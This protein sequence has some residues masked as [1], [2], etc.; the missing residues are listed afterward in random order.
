MF[1]FFVTPLAP[2]F[3]WVLTVNSL[4]LLLFLLFPLLHTPLLVYGP[5][6]LIYV[7][8]LQA[9]SMVAYKRLLF[10]MV[11]VNFLGL[12][13][14]H[15]RPRLNMEVSHVEEKRDQKGWNMIASKQAIVGSLFF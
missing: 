2:R 13:G 6:Q 10:A 8:P 5:E 11:S 15:G 3:A 14:R 12:Y 7:L 9:A 4:T 1:L